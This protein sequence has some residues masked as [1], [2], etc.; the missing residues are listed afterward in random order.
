MHFPNYRDFYQRGLIPIGPKDQTALG[1]LSAP[2]ISHWL[3]ALE[4]KAD[5]RDKEFWVWNIVIF[6]TN[7]AGYFHEK[8]PYFVSSSFDNFHKAYE[9]ATEIKETCERDR[10]LS[11]TEKIS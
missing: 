2:D 9:A 3:V 7:A 10:L 5:H 4:G 1:N 11:S 8:Q 6:Q